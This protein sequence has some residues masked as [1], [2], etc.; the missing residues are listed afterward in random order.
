M[1]KEDIS[2]QNK[3]LF[4][5]TN[6]K[7]LIAS[8]VESCVLNLKDPPSCFNVASEAT[9]TIHSNVPLVGESLKS[10]VRG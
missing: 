5:A 2:M 6:N 8:I 7:N 9:I 3:L 4:W 10:L 1:L